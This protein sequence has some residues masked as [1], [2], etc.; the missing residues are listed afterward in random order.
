M[1][2]VAALGL[3]LAG[4]S[5]EPS[6]VDDDGGRRADGRG[7]GDAGVADAEATGFDAG[8][9]ARPF[10][11]ATDCPADY[12]DLGVPGSRYRLPGPPLLGL[13]LQ[14]WANADGE[15]RAQA[16]DHP[17]VRL[18]V[19]DDAAEQAAITARV[20]DLHFST[21]MW[22]G[23]ADIDG[24]GVWTRPGGQ[25]A[26]YLPWAATEP[27]AA[28]PGQAMMIEPLGEVVRSRSAQDGYGWVCECSA[29]P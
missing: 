16:L 27:G 14:A 7:A 6:A 29:P 12:Q 4:C 28:R 13:P 23:V 22:T 19:F 8:V 2:R 10:N 20:R 18:V 1:R 26:T 15:C 21:W 24:D 17:A 9:D 25:V 3:V 5:F 11:P